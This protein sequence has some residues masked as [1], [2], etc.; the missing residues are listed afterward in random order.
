V[1]NGLLTLAAEQGQL[2]VSDKDAADVKPKEQA[3]KPKAE[4]E[5]K[6]NDE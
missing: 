5:E 4:E 3:D 2:Y 6:K 1:G